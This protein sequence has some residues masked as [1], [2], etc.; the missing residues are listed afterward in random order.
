MEERQRVCRLIRRKN[1][2]AA[3]DFAGCERQLTCASGGR[4]LRWNAHAAPV[5]RELPA[6]KRAADAI[7]DNTA[8]AKIRAHMP[9]SRIERNGTPVSCA[10]SNDP[11][12]EERSGDDA[13]GQLI[14]RREEV[15]SHRPVRERGG[16]RRDFVR[17]PMP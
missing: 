13:T 8:S 10:I 3:A 6:V 4:H 16:R 1:E 11:S 15:P 14:R 9:A 7:T 17:R 5:G 12:S 2:Y